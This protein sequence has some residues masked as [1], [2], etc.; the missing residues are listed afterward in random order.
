VTVGPGCG[1]LFKITTSGS[2]GVVHKFTGTDG[3]VPQGALVQVGSSLYGTTF[4]GGAK[5]VGTVF[6]LKP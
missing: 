4:Q 1:T 6:S 2:F 3:A 5:N